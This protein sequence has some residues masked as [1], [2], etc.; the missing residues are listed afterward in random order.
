MM[1]PNGVPVL[2]TCKYHAK[3]KWVSAELGRGHK[4]CIEN[5]TEK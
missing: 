3:Q 2:P 5:N 1:F 4:L